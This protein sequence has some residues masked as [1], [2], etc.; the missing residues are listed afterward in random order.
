MAALRFGNGGQT[1]LVWRDFAAVGP[2][3]RQGAFLEHFWNVV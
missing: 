2:F 3:R 1:P